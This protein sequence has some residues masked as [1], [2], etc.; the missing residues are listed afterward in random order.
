MIGGGFSGAVALGSQFDK[1][2]VVDLGFRQTV[3]SLGVPFSAQVMRTLRVHV[4]IGCPK[5]FS[6]AVSSGK[7]PPC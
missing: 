4:L 7:G 6:M 1:F 5:I 2:D 3:Y